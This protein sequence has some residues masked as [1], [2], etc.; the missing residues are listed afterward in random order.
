M[1]VTL[2][3]NPA[4]D[5]TAFLDRLQP[6]AL[7][8]LQRTVQDIGGKGI[9]VSR[10]VAALGGQSVA[11]G[12][13]AGATGDHLAAVLAQTPGI[14]ADF[15]HLEEGETRTNLKIV[16]PGGA[17]TELNETGPQASPAALQALREKLLQ[18]AAPGAWFV[19][20]G[21]VGPGVPWDFYAD[22]TAQL[23]ARGAKV[24][25]DADGDLFA[26]AVQAKPDC[27]KPNAYELSQYFGLDHIAT[28]AELLTLGRELTGCGVGAVC[29]SMGASGACLISAEGAWQA[30][31]LPVPVASSV[32][33]GDAMVGALTF[34]L[35]RG[36]GMEQAFR[37]AMA[38]SAAAVTTHGTRPP[39]RAQVEQLIARVAL[40]RVEG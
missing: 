28:D 12:L 5:K 17:L 31:A 37:L 35:H 30:P 1:I 34:A 11:C 39:Q 8:R 38:A 25:V 3:M 40:R 36:D 10:T 29:I 19:L 13:L 26:A 7:N 15:L 4:L 24:F 21:S 16:E 22:L 6:H 27:I 32:G 23:H 18:R 9:N 33:A 2:T 14:E 20:A